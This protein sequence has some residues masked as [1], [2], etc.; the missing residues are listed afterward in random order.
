MYMYGG[1]DERP[2]CFSPANTV[3]DRQKRFFRQ[4][5]CPFDE[6][7]FAAA[8]FECGARCSGPITPEPG[9]LQVTM[10]LHFDL[11]HHDPVVRHLDLRIIRT[12]TISFVLCNL[13]NWKRI[14]EMHHPIWIEWSYV[15]GRSGT[16]SNTQTG[17]IR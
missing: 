12:R 2:A 13:R 6:Q 1:S 7:A 16:Y 9:W 14:Y 5:I 15:C 4:C 17:F 3:I 11:P 10:D 8:R